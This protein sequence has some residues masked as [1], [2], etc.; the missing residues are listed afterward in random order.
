[1]YFIQFQHLLSECDVPVHQIHSGM[2][3]FN[4]IIIDADRY[5]VTI[6]AHVTAGCITTQSAFR[7][8][9]FDVTGIQRCQCIDMLCKFCIVRFKC[10]FP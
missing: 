8:C 2:H 1:M 7:N 9:A 5:M 10:I 4:Q 3:C 6:H